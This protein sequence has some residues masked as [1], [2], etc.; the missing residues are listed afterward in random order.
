M[1]QELKLKAFLTSNFF[2]KF[3]IILIFIENFYLK[4]IKNISRILNK[5][6]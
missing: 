1:Q 4:E 2:N 6:I 3:R 5:N